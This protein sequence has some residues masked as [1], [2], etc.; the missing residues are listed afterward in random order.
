MFYIPLISNPVGWVILGLGGY[1]LY[2]SGKKKG[3]EE[4]AASQIL[5]VPETVSPTTEDK[6]KGDK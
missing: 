5:P 2:K 3:Q 1:A 4:V 6:N